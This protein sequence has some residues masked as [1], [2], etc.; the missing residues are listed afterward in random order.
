MNTTEEV[1]TKHSVQ[2]PAHLVADA[3]VKVCTGISRQGDIIVIPSRRGKVSGLVPV[4]PEGIPVVRG[5]AGG[6]T[7]L[8]VADG[9]VSWAPRTSDGPA[10]GTLDVEEGVAYLLH[11]EHGAAGVG[12]GQY[13]ARRQVEQADAIRLVQD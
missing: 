1:M 9:T 13:T 2:I 3:E 8:L 5:E 11:P 7:H 6:N 12:V 4:P 10:L